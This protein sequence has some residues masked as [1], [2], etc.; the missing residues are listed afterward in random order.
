MSISRL[1]TFGC[2]YTKHIWPTW[3][4]IIGTSYESYYNLGH[5]G[6][7]NYYIALKLYEAQLKYSISKHDTVI[8]MLSSANRFD[9][10][11]EKIGKFNLNGNLYL[12]EKILGKKFIQEVWNDTHSIYN[13]WFSAKTIKTILDNIGCKYKIV[14]AFGLFKTDEGLFLKADSSIS[15]LQKDYNQFVYTKESL[16]DFSAKYKHLTYIMNGSLEGHP[17]IMI[18]HDFIKEHMFEFYNSRMNEI[19][20]KWESSISYVTNKGIYLNGD[21]YKNILKQLI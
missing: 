21:S 15:K 18:N 6:A 8:V 19:S 17:T 13:T 1:F 2:S 3:A 10:Y 12:S 9:F 7:G 11:D 5:P 20:Q 14:E 16:S 4:D